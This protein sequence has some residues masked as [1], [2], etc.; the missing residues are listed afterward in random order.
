MPTDPSEDALS[1]LIEAAY[2]QTLARFE[3]EIAEGTRDAQA[4]LGDYRRQRRNYASLLRL[5]QVPEEAKALADRLLQSH[6]LVL[7][8][9]V[10][11]EFERDVARLL[12]RLYDEFIAHTDQYNR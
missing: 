1:Q 11:D 2:R 5:G 7:P 3:K 12:I 6:N 10:Q 4:E 9:A 8:V